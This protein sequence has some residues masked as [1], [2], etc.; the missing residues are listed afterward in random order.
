MTIAAPLHAF[1]GLR[2]DRRIARVR[3]VHRLAGAAIWRPEWSG[4]RSCGNMRRF[5]GHPGQAG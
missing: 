3:V 4:M 1:H 5:N 2:G